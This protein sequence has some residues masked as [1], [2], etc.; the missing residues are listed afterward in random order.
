MHEN[1]A[2]EDEGVRVDL[3]DDAATTGSD[4]S[5][6][7]VGLCVLTK[8]FEVEVVDRWVLRFVKCGTRTGNV[9]NV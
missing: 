6:D 7:A 8:R 1:V 4:V 9:L 5:K 2:A 3:S